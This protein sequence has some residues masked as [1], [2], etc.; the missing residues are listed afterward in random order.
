VLTLAKFRE[1]NQNQ[2]MLLP[3]SLEEKIP[4]R[5]LSRVVSKVI[6][7]LDIKDIEETYSDL[8]THGYHPRMLLKVVLYGYSIGVRS[9]RKIQRG[10]REDLVFMWLAGMQEPD[11]RTISD[12]RKAKIK[13]VKKLFRQV[14]DSCKE[15]G[16]VKCGTICLDGT[17]IQANNSKNKMIY[18]K[19]LEKR[20]IK[21]EDEI[22]K[23][24]EEAERIDREEDEL[25][26]DYDGYSLDRMPS[27]KEI[28]K[29]VK[30]VQKKREKM[31]RRWNKTVE[32]AEVVEERLKRM[33][34]NR[35]SNGNTDKDATLMQMKEGYLAPGYNVQF[36]TEN[37][38]IVSYGVFPRPADMKLL[39]PMIEEI[40]R[41]T[42]KIP[43]VIIADKGY[44]SHINYE[45]LKEKDIKAAIPYP[46]YDYDRIALKKG[47]YRPSKRTDYEKVK[48]KTQ[49]FL[50]T[51]EGKK[52]LE[53]RKNDVEPV[54][55]NIKHNLKFRR[56]LLRLKPKIILETGLIAIAHN[57]KK[58]EMFLKRGQL[59]PQLG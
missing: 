11:F 10:T 47:T 46:N 20:M 33:G 5:H 19:S 38:V 57:I 24:L 53:S 28:E 54:I 58:I 9:S 12:F 52:L 36:A 31:E 4:E 25:Y 56:F 23:I 49:E 30:K 50:A 42:G 21:Y 8:G 51:E 45:Y 35:N 1:Y 2:I 55:G 7:N 29:A 48:K 43:E 17:K 40:E 37:Q 41:D 6:E 22:D 39:K 13:D 34:N 3:P 26:G 16:L 44:G 15:I 59:V 32:K 27:D 18:R 14:L